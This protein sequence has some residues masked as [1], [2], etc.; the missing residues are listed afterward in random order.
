M[1]AQP[2]GI[3]A[4]KFSIA[5]EMMQCFKELEVWELFVE[6]CV[7]AFFILRRRANEVVS[8]CI[9]SFTASGR[10]PIEIRDYVRGP[11]S[12]MLAMPDQKARSILTNMITSS[13]KN[14]QN[15]FK[16]FTHKTIDPI[17][18]GMLEKHFPPATIAMAVVES[19]STTPKQQNNCTKKVTQPNILH[20]DSPTAPAELRKKS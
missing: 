6:K 18:Y 17:W 7:T 5:N 11:E 13:A 8:A 10:K 20:I 14:W 19:S 2:P 3:D 12:L 4:P 16:Q 1:G 15:V 9:Y